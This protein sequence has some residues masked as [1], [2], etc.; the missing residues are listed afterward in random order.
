MDRIHRM[1]VSGVVAVGM[2]LLSVA[3]PTLATSRLFELLALMQASFLAIVISVSLLSVQITSS[4]GAPLLADLYRDRVFS[5]LLVR[6]GTSILVALALF[7]MVPHL[8]GPALR[9]SAVAAGVGTAGY[10]FL[11]LLKLEGRLLSFL[12]PEPVLTDLV[13]RV[14]F[15]RYRTFATR[16]RE[17]GR[18]ARNPALEIF[19]IAQTSLDNRDHY[20]ALQAVAALK[21]ATAQI[22]AQ[23]GDVADAEQ[24]AA[25]GSIHKLFDYWN[26][27]AVQAVESGADDVLHAIVDAEVEL[28]TNALK[29]SLRR[30]AVEG[31]RSLAYFCGVAADA[32]RLEPH[33]WEALLSLLDSAI[34]AND[35]EVTNTVVLNIADLIDRVDGRGELGEPN[36]RDVLLD[37][38]SEAWVRAK[39]KGMGEEVDAQFASIIEDLLGTHPG[40]VTI[41]DLHMVENQETASRVKRYFE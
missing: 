16:R 28:T 9:A 22:L 37:G 18:G 29:A 35:P 11:S 17:E 7:G 3:Y 26:R 21:S 24:V 40:D 15:D 27:I 1:A 30:P 10:S 8:S 39:A 5:R 12:D 34:D 2:G 41:E 36:P 25:A 6:F 20:G 33:C 19:Q 4:R 38:V 14:S 23:Y 13:D 31:V 32:D